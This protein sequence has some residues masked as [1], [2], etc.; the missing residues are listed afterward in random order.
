MLYLKTKIPSKSIN[1][2]EKVLYKL[3]GN[4][5]CSIKVLI[6]LNSCI[7]GPKIKG[8]IKKRSLK[9]FAKGVSSQCDNYITSSSKSDSVHL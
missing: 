4:F 8:Y 5:L 2:E 7:V 3:L 9:L 1:C 6:C